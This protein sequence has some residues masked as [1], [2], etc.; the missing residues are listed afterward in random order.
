MMYFPF[1]EKK[2]KIQNKFIKK[3][4]IRLEKRPC[5]L[6]VSLT[7]MP[8]RIDKIYITIETL[9]TQTVKP[10]RIQ[11]WLGQ[12][13]LSVDDL[14]DNLLRQQARGLEICW[15][16]KTMR[17]YDKLIPA[18]ERHHDCIIV[19]VDDDVLYPPWWLE[20][21]YDAW[22][23]NAESIICYRAKNIKMLAPERFAPYARWPN[24]SG[25]A[26]AFDI[27]PTGSSGV[28]YPPGCLA[29]EVLNKKAFT[30]L[31]PTADDIWFKAMSLINGTSCRRVFAENKKWHSIPSS[32]AMS[33]SKHNNKGTPGERPNDI[34]LNNV[35]ERY[36]LY[37]MLTVED[38]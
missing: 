28:L 20:K 2:F 12:D 10:D 31:S 33:L 5:Q 38:K 18:L 16:D 7:S 8:S 35:W 30:E 22:Q 14:P 3:S 11:L 23:E 34:Q 36:D 25:N 13:E 24:I 37:K 32:Q 19:T 9:L 26:P 4:G 17:S 6:I 1:L 29:S 21:L 27:F 15:I